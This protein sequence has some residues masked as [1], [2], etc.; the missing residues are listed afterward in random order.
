VKLI[1]ESSVGLGIPDKKV[2]QRS[3]KVNAVFIVQFF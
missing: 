1:L 3:S 2:I